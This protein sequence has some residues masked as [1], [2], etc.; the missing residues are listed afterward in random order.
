M[1]RRLRPQPAATL[2]LI[3][4]SPRL[5][6]LPLP[7]RRH[8]I[9]SCN[10]LF[11]RQRIVPRVMKNTRSSPKEFVHT[12]GSPSAVCRFDG[13]RVTFARLPAGFLDPSQL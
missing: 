6:L 2:T 8:S 13:I 9:N 5:A 3:W 12:R 4:L 1:R 7:T 11:K 10:R